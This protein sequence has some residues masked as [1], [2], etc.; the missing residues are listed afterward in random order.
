MARIVLGSYLVR[1]PLGGNM[2]CVLQYLL[3]LL[4]LG[5]EMYFVEKSGYSQSCY[6]VSKNVMTDDCSYGMRVVGGLL[7]R[8]GLGDRWCYVDADERYHG[9]G[10]ERVQA[11]F[12]SADLFIE[13]GTHE[14]WLA[15]AADA[16][17]RVLVDGDPSF[18]Q[19]WMENRAAA[20][21]HVPRY[22]HY[23][24]VGSN[25]GTDRSTAPTAGETWRHLFH[26]VMLSL[27]PAGSPNPDAP[28]TTVMNWESYAP[29]EYKGRQFGHKNLE[30]RKFMGLPQATAT[31]LELAVAGPNVPADL[32]RESG[33]R[34]RDAHSAT[35][36]FDSYAEYIRGSKGEFTVCKNGFVATQ[37]G[38]FGDRSSVYLASG[39]PVIMQD[40]GFGSR[41]PCGR[42]LFAV[43]TVDDAVAAIDEIQGN[44]EYHSRWARAIA[45]EFLDAPLV[46]G[47]FLREIG[48]Q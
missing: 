20:G 1:Y 22:D 24:T 3:G 45:N 30:F 2:S 6:D 13:M 37:C 39:R 11:I 14:A 25:V 4:H 12:K 19:M 29:V 43:R 40:T 26:P 8:F 41:L 31:P 5:H 46:L 7:A 17:L 28:F 47:R 9:L 48:V 36:S 16:E 35:I 32:L 15:E 38:W 34:V 10:R 21:E 23:Y 18:S 33:W 42:G 27:F 44:Y